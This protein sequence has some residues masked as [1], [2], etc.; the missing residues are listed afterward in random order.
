MII[1]YVSSTELDA[2]Y[3][4]DGSADQVQINNALTYAHTNGTF[5]SPITVYL[6]GPYIYDLTDS[7]LVGSNTILTGDATAIVRLHNSASWGA[8]KPLINQ[9]SGVIPQN[10]TL[11]NITL[12]GNYANQPEYSAGNWGKGYYPGLYLQGTLSNPVRNVIIH[13][14]IIKN[15]LTDG[16]RISYGN[17]FEFYNN[18]TIE[19]MHEGVFVLRSLNC[20][21]YNNDFTIRTNSGPRC[22][23]SQNVNIYGN[24]MRPYALN[25]V[26]GNFG[27]QIE[28]NSA[29]GDIIT[30]NINCYNN[31][32]TDCWGGGIWCIDLRGTATNKNIKIHDNTITGCGRITTTSYNAGICIQGFNDIEVYN[33]IIKNNYNAGILIPSA[34]SGGSGYIYYYDDNVV[35]GTLDTLN[36][37]KSAGHGFGIVNRYPSVVTV[38]GHGNIVTGNVNGDYYQVSN[39]NDVSTTAPI[40]PIPSIRINETDEIV[41]YYVDNYSAYVNGYPIKILGYDADTDQSISTDKPPG[42]DGWVLG[43]FGS[44]GCSI[45]VRCFGFG[46]HD[47]RRAV[48]AWKKQGRTFVE[49]GGDSAGWQV[50]GVTRAHASR[51]DL[52]AGDIVSDDGPNNYNIVFYCDTPFEESVNKHV[53]ARKLTYS[54]ERWSSDNTYAGNIVKNASFEEWTRDTTQSWNLKTPAASVNFTCVEFSPDLEQYCAVADSGT[55]NRIQISSFGNAW[56]IPATNPANVNINWKGAAWGDTVGIESTGDPAP[57]VMVSSDNYILVSSDDYILVSGDMS[58]ATALQNGRW[59]IVGYSAATNG[60]AYSEDGESWTAGVTPNINL[61]DVCYV[62][63]IDSGIYRYI[64]VASSGADRVI[65]TDDGGETWTAVSSADDAETWVSVDYATDIKTIVAVASSGKIMHSVDYG[66]SW[67]LATAPSQIWN[68]VK[69]AV[70]LGLFVATSTNGTQQIATS[71]TGESWTLQDVPY[72]GTSIVPGGGDLETITY[73]TD[74]ALPGIV[75]TSAATEYTSKDTS[76][77]LTTALPALTGGNI[78]RIDQISCKLRTLLAG[79]VAYLKVTIQAASLYSGVETQIVEWTNN[80]STYITKSLD[81]ALESETDEAVIF[82]YYMKTSDS[83]YRAAA[84]ALGYKATIQST[85]GGTVGYN[86]NEWTGLAIADDLKYIVAVAQTGTGN[87]LM[88][89]TNAGIWNLA[90]FASDRAWK[91]GCF[92]PSQMKFVMVGSSGA[93]MTS[94][95]YGTYRADGWTYGETSKPSR[96]E[97]SND[98]YLSLCITGDGITEEPGMITQPAQFAAGTTY[99]LTGYCEK[100]GSSGSAV[101]DIAANGQVLA[102]IE[103]IDDDVF[104]MKQSFIKFDVIPPDAMI[105]IHGAGTPDNST[106]MYFDTVCVQKL[107]DYEVFE[108]GVDILTT[109]TVETIPDISI[110]ALGSLSGSVEGRETAGE[111]KTHTDATNVGG[112]VYTTYQLQD[113]FNYTI[114]GVV[115]KKYRIDKVGIKGCTA[116]SGGRC[117]SKIEVYFG[118]TL[119]GTYTFSSS[120]VLYSY[121]THSAAPSITAADGQSVTFKY[122]LKTSDAA[123]RAYIRDATSTITEVLE[124]PT[125]TIDAG[126]SIYNVADPLTVLRLCNKI[127]PGIT[128]TIGAD[129]TGNIKYSENFS[130]S[131]YQTTVLS[132]SGDSYSESLKRVTLTG[133]LVWEFDT[134]Y[135]ITGIPYV[136]LYIVSGIPKLEISTDNM[137]W[138]ACDSNSTV[139]VTDST[140]SRELDNASAPLRLYG[141]TKFYMRLSPASGT[142][143]IKSVYMF[144]YLI[145]IDAEHPVIAPTGVAETFAVT[146]SNNVP[147]I[148]TMK[149]SNKHWV[150]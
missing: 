118:S 130:D 7:L 43:D 64:A 35:S 136:I 13:N 131:T 107:T 70:Y 84:T 119:R 8:W 24:T 113:F 63:D 138:T 17:G 71:T 89:S 125:V 129:G 95:D 82:R 54:G 46:K 59:V 105:R 116:S 23:N 11:S 93:I 51:K 10:F 133:S 57:F 72:G 147:C 34:P 123:K 86:Y 77:E 32:I 144:S 140:V 115:G 31:T 85:T 141:K 120:T 91:S 109:G 143:I 29:Q 122:Y 36:P 102:S 30:N 139:G 55:G 26:A 90:A 62:K 69:R 9:I 135:P 101:I 134:L 149:Y 53:R 124:T 37:S 38:A 148:I 92:S 145:T 60:A 81:L 117:D 47:V 61:E 2:N 48:A 22:Y 112:T 15:M 5:V 21:I 52:D 110:Q 67:T 79:K 99:S 75:Y 28:D 66:I 74:I 104:S 68:E 132:R 83:N 128:L 76:L 1:I 88:N 49:L 114:T 27:I 50:S 98:G 56:A 127:Y 80:T 45:N 150:V 96:S 44:D 65:Y 16:A 94:E 4:V 100:V 78:Y 40:K 146:M 6:R 39:I 19:C 3:K 20:N 25:S 42:F 18:K 111:S 121:T 108:N 142:L 97:Y 126:I 73:S 106:S 12:D 87:R 33:N 14:T 58:T 103:W 41:D 137:T